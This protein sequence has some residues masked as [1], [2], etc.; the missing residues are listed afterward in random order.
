MSSVEAHAEGHAYCELTPA[1]YRATEEQVGHVR[2]GDEQQEPHRCE[3]NPSRRSSGS[4][5][6]LLERED[7][8]LA[9][10]SGLANDPG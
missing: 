6:L 8:R 2:A 5:H 3:Q 9:R 10:R 1:A 7:R 4:D